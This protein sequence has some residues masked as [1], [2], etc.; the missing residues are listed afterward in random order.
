ML[1]IAFYSTIKPID[2]HIA[3]GVRLISKN[4]FDSLNQAGFQ[5]RVA[6][7]FISYLKRPVTEKLIE[8]KQEALKE[9]QRI[10]KSWEDEGYK[11]DLFFT[12]HPYCKAPDWIGEFI[13]QSLSIPR[14]TLE[15]CRTGQTGF[16]AHRL[17]GQK[18]FLS[19]DYHFYFKPIDK[20]YL[21]SLDVPEEK[22][23][24]L[25]PFIDK[26]TSLK[27]IDPP[28]GPL[29]SVVGMMR[30]G[31]KVLNYKMLAEILTELKDEDW[32]LAV[33]GDGVGKE[34]IRAAFGSI[35]QDKILWLGALKREEVLAWMKASQA[36]IWPGHL[37]PIGMVFLEA[38]SVGTPCIAFN[39]MGV[40]LVVYD[41]ETGL[42]APE[43]DLVQF[44]ENLKKVLKDGTF[45]KKLGDQ[46]IEKQ[47]GYHSLESTAKTFK[48]VLPQIVD[49]YLKP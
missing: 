4:V 12:Y 17:E 44:R 25:P 7:S 48:K 6:T 31:K 20:D 10:L 5:T 49:S 21:K 22:L 18:T 14:V 38:A 19:A 1:K 3:C 29:F 45:V 32:K 43:N 23:F 30:P 36:M 39:S 27:K 9:A 34:E 15:A 35:P 2:H 37:E 24:H 40:P 11:P 8:R 42:L 28:E 33:V 13:S 41:N 46:A 47:A 26:L 16:E